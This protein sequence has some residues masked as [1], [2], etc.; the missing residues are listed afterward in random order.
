MLG[1][2]NNA[3]SILQTFCLHG[4]FQD[5]RTISRINSSSFIHWGGF[6]KGFQK[7]APLLLFKILHCRAVKGMTQL[8]KQS[9]GQ[10]AGRTAKEVQ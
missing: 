7:Y 2:E 4:P 3:L 8:E 6:E 10:C 9:R 1:G 5:L